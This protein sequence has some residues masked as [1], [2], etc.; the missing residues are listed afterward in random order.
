MVDLRDEGYGFLRLHGY[1]PSRD[2]AYIS[3]KQTRQF[4]LR[5]GDTVRGKSRPPARNEKNPALL[6]V[7]SVNG[8]EAHN[9]PPRPRFD[10]LI[11]LFPQERLTLELADDPSNATAR[12]IDLLAPIGKGTRGLIA[13][14]PKAGK[15]S[16][17]KQIVRSIEVNHPDVELF[18]VLIDERPE[19]ITEM[20]RW[21]LR[22]SVASSAVDRPADE[23]TAGA[24]L[25]VE[26]AKRRVEAGIVLDGLTRL[27]RAYDL[28]APAGG[29]LLAGGLDASA[30]FPTK[31]LFGAARNAEEGGSLTILATAVVGTG[32]ATDQAIF[33][34]FSGSENQEI[35]LDRT[36]ADRRLFPAIDIEASSTRHDDLLVDKAQLASVAALRQLLSARIAESGPAAGLELLLERLAASKSNADL[37]AKVAKG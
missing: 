14:P 36:L 1:L 12:A 6:Q 37:L 27:A 13:S 24:E 15:T 32:S 18:V 17:I 10:E 34:S 3:V 9:Q 4:G 23:H 21:L 31:Q 29:R 20:K 33:D 16:T 19:E 7:D 8:Y 11:V 25:V 2:D 30:V 35:K 5:T 26:K 28:V 22:G